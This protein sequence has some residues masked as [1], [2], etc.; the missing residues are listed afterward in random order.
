MKNIYLILLFIS[1]F[2][3]SQNKLPEIIC[4]P[5]HY[6]TIKLKYLLSNQER[7]KPY[8]NEFEIRNL[9]A[10]QEINID[11][12]SL[13]NILLMYQKNKFHLFKQETNIYYAG[14]KNYFTYND[15]QL[16]SD[17]SINIR[18]KYPTLS[19]FI[20]LLENRELECIY[21][22]RLFPISKIDNFHAFYYKE[23]NKETGYYVTEELGIFNSLNSLIAHEY[24]SINNYIEIYQNRIK[25]KNKGN[26]ISKLSNAMYLLP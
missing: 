6:D 2:C 5:F 18:E 26:L 24:G 11:I 13:N 20:K 22:I 12:D 19:R 14:C 3:L 9:I 25:D 8:L 21:A 15:N 16:N 23:K 10:V 4:E 17:L 1:N 7:L